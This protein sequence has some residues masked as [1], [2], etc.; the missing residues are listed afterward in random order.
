MPASNLTFNLPEEETEFRDALNGCQW[1]AV[2]DET[3]SA[4]RDVRKYGSL[5]DGS[6]PTE[7]QVEALLLLEKEIRDNMANRNLTLDQ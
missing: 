2:V 6:K 5:P 1:K 7:N 3:L 4:I